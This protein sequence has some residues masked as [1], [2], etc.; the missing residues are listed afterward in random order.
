MPESPEAKVE[1][2]TR[3]PR[4]LVALLL[5][6]IP[7]AG[8]LYKGHTATGIGFLAG[9]VVA[10]VG[11]VIIATFT[12]GFGLLLL[13]FYWLWVMAQAFFIDDLVYPEAPAKL[14]EE[15]PKGE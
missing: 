1:E 4:H 9:T 2:P 3:N 13:P 8:H 10:V 11:C 7:G 5:S 14:P 15:T 6:V 12:A